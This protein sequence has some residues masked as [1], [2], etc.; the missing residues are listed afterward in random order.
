MTRASFGNAGSHVALPPHKHAGR[1]SV[2]SL[3][4]HISIPVGLP[5]GTRGIF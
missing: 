4:F 5:F 3:Y 1:D 2:L